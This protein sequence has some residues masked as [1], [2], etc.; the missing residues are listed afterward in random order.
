M[1]KDE[2]EFFKILFSNNVQE[3]LSA[4]CSSTSP[5]NKE[6]LQILMDEYKIKKLDETTTKT[7]LCYQLRKKVGT[8]SFLTM[9]NNYWT[10]TTNSYLKSWNS[11]KYL[12]HIL[13]RTKELS[14]SI[15]FQYLLIHGDEVKLQNVVAAVSLAWPDVDY[16]L[17]Q[18]ENELT[19]LIHF[20]S[21]M[22]L[23][24][25]N[26]LFGISWSFSKIYLKLNPSY[27]FSTKL[28]EKDLEIAITMKNWFETLNKNTSQLRTELLSDPE[29]IQ[30]LNGFYTKEERLNLR[31]VVEEERAY[32]NMLTTFVVFNSILKIFK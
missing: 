1:K 15:L 31:N 21:K 23:E 30:S 6:F 22:I 13:L 29:Y 16:P 4:L 3:I 20:F 25:N 18:L 12:K 14:K 5:F 9:F 26:I 28:K 32:S 8:I 17:V 27:W 10:K 7:S 2:F 11:N 19:L 24:L